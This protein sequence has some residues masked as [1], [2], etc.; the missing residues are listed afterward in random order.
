MLSHADAQRLTG[1]SKP[2]L[3]EATAGN[4]DLV[5]QSRD[6]PEERRSTFGAKVPLLVVVLRRVIKR[7]DA[8]SPLL[9]NHGTSIKVG[10]DAERAARSPLAIAAVTDSQRRGRRVHCD[11]CLSAG[12]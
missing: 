4:A 6:V 10:G 9:A 3:S 12:T 5:W 2:L 1:L 11:Q 7:V 8:R